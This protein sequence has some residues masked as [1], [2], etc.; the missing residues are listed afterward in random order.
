MLPKGKTLFFLTFTACSTLA[1]ALTPTARTQAAD[2]EISARDSFQSRVSLG[3]NKQD[4][5]YLVTWSDLAR[6]RMND[7]N[8]YGR[9]VD[10]NG[11]PVSKDIG[12][13]TGAKGQAISAV[14]YD[15]HKK[16]YLVTWS[17]WRNATTVESDIYGQFVNA[18]GSLQGKNFVISENRAAS[19]KDVAVS[20]DPVR[21]QY[22][23]AWKHGSSKG[24]ELI[25]A[26][27]IT[28]DGRAKGDEFQVAEGKGK[29]DRPSLYFDPKRQRF[30]VLWR[31]TVDGHLEKTTAIRGK[32]IFSMFIN[33]DKPHK[34]APGKLIDIEDDACLPTSLYA[35]AYSPD[36]D[37]FM[38]SWTTGR[39]Y[40]K[41]GLD[42]WGAIISAETGEHMVKP[43]AIARANDYQE[44]PTVTYDRH[45]KR[46]LAVWYDL[47]R[48][49]GAR[50]ADIYGR[51]VDA[52]GKMSDEFVISDLNM[53][54][55]RRFPVVAYNAARDSYLVFWQDQRLKTPER[56]YAK[57]FGTVKAGSGVK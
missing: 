42:S 2:F 13:A 41:L 8:I 53:K 43:F 31:D 51:F 32:G 25:R 44:F 7:V 15:Q 47:R 34:A 19:Q 9:L 33:P 14:A 54:G 12:I 48:D 30:L 4:G 45:N 17:D 55:A 57:I 28:A 5:H 29:Q 52:S 26:R 36:A 27:Y 20:Y 11:K 40:Q 18:N 23:V 16:R 21:R 6:D 49:H 39:D 1:Y 56:P 37:V 3:A 50:N 24:P 35:A 46:F 22:L 10:A 38:V